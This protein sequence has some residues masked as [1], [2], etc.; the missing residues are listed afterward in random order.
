M[1]ASTFSRKRPYNPFEV[2]VLEHGCRDVE[3]LESPYTETGSRDALLKDRAEIK[4]LRTWRDEGRADVGQH[5]NEIDFEISGVTPA[6]ANLFRRVMMTHIPTVAVDIAL[7]H[8]NDSVVFDEA[9]AHRLGL[10]PLAVDADKLSPVVAGK[11]INTTAPDPLT[12][13][14]FE[15]DVVAPRDNYPVYSKDFKWVPLEGGPVFATPPAPV[16][17]K[18]MLTKLMKGHRLKVTMFAIRGTGE[19]HAKWAA[20]GGCTFKPAPIV[21]VVPGHPKAVGEAAEFIANRCP[22][23]VFDIEDAVLT[24]ADEAGCSM[25]RE[26]IRGDVAHT[27]P[28]P[29]E[30]GVHKSRFIFHVESVGIYTS[31]SLFARALRAYASCLRQ[32][33]Q[34]VGHSYPQPLVENTDIM[35]EDYL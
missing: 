24:V 19:Q 35:K 21:R 8:A 5:E 29:V 11:G 16:H 1:A 28:S 17:D 7:F 15:L 27:A 32:L 23:K 26:C 34:D 10:V 2:V 30:L 18:I 4:I 20:V 33:S 14:R 12:T 3:T 31:A 22:G 13:L 9:L 6:M 25:C